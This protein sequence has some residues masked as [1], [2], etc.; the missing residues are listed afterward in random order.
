MSVC[1]A[2]F[3]RQSR[4]GAMLVFA[5][6][7]LSACGGSDEV[8]MDPNKSVYEAID[9][10][11]GPLEDLNIK[12]RD[13]P[14]LLQKATANPYA[15]PKN[16]RCL[17]VREELAELDAL[18]GEDIQP[19]EIKTS[20]LGDEVTE[21]QNTE[22]P[23]Q[24]DLTDGA[25]N[26]A[27]DKALSAIRLQTNVIPFRSVV[28]SITGANRHQRKVAEAYEAGKLRR[29]YLKGFAVERFGPGCLTRA[30][31]VKKPKP[32]P[33]VE[34]PVEPKAAPKVDSNFDPNAEIVQTDS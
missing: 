21:L 11:T 29:A 1:S 5:L 9:A 6:C 27:R 10:A 16:A 12:Q 20:S 30:M 17:T 34:A 23:N 13:I 4:N 15:R 14:E 2:Q 24:S 18:L 8:V 22:I 3:V 19:K 33:K 31:P 7:C 32:E 28:R 25:V 26:M